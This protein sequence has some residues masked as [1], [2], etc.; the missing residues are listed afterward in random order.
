MLDRHR[1]D[2]MEAQ[3]RTLGRDVTT[4]SYTQY[5]QQVRRTL[6]G[7]TYFLWRG[8]ITFHTYNRWGRRTRGHGGTSRTQVI[9]KL[10]QL[11]LTPLKNP[12]AARNPV[13]EISSASFNKM[14]ETKVRFLFFPFLHREI[15]WSVNWVC[16]FDKQCPTSIAG[17]YVWTLVSGL[18]PPRFLK[19]W[20]VRVI[21]KQQMVS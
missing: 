7:F 14:F 4:D 2:V 12:F 1:G 21:L 15:C 16:P 9:K 19:K 6:S 10:S 3:Q 17:A 18:L 13:T 5:L 8:T 20:K 11:W